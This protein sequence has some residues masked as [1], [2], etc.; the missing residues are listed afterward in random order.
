MSFISMHLFIKLSHT[1]DGS[2]NFVSV[3]LESINRNVLPIK[4]EPIGQQNVQIGKL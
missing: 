1:V 3:W 2:L 4:A